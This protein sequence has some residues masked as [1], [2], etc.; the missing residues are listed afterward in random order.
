MFLQLR[1]AWD[2]GE[3]AGFELHHVQLSDREQAIGWALAM[4]ICHNSGSGKLG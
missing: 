3:I 2:A 1:V 4:W